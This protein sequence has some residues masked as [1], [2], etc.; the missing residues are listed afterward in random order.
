MRIGV[1][2]DRRRDRRPAAYPIRPRI[3]SIKADVEY[4]P[5]LQPRRIFHLEGTSWRAQHCLQTSERRTDLAGIGRK[6]A[7]PRALSRRSRFCKRCKQFMYGSASLLYKAAFLGSAGQPVWPLRV[8]LLHRHTLRE[9]R[10]SGGIVGTRI[11]RER[12]SKSEARPHPG[13]HVKKWQFVVVTLA[14]T[15]VRP[16]KEGFIGYRANQLHRNARQ[17]TVSELWGLTI[18]LPSVHW[19]STAERYSTKVR[20]PCAGKRSSIMRS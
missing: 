13:R 20:L 8:A 7:Y 5:P 15:P 14:G 1:A 2:S 9:T 4:W 3:A 11:E 17:R 12:G 19:K 6:A 18:W 10:G 16:G